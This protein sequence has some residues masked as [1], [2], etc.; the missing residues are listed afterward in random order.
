MNPQRHTPTPD[1]LEAECIAKNDALQSL[2]DI[3]RIIAYGGAK[4][5]PDAT[6]IPAKDWNNI[7]AILNAH[8]DDMVGGNPPTL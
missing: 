3:A 8:G 6:I 1:L 7:I 5:A 4:I 2:A